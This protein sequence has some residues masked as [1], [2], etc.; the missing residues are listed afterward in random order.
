MSNKLEILT[1]LRNG[2]EPKAIAGEL[3]VSMASVV[4]YR[5]ELNNAIRD[6][7]LNTLMASAAPSASELVDY[8]F[9]DSPPEVKAAA[10]E[11]SKGLKALERLQPELIKTASALNSRI[12]IMCSTAEN[13]G[14]LESLTLALCKLQSSFFPAAGPNTQ[15][16]IQNNNGGNSYGQ[17]L[18]DKPGTV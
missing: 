5:T 6:D 3:D 17:W 11:L 14:E 15:V 13:V 2:D 4:R 10:N 1:R 9:Q 18:S 16:N 8:T 12:A 7:K